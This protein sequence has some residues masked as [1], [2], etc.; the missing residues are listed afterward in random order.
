MYSYLSMKQREGS[1]VYH[2]QKIQGSSMQSSIP[3]KLCPGTVV[4][5]IFASSILTFPGMIGA[6][7]NKSREKMVVI[8]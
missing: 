5:I 8:F 3:L 6:F 2:S 1:P 4:P 7:L